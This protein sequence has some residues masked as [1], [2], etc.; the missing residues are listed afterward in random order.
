[1]DKQEVNLPQ[2]ADAPRGT[3]SARID[4][5]GR[6]KLPM[7]VKR[8]L[9]RKSGGRVYC[10]TLDGRM[11]HIFPL[12]EWTKFENELARFTADPQLA[13]DVLIYADN[14]GSDADVDEAGR[15]LLPQ[16]LRRKLN[17][18][19]APEKAE[20]SPVDTVWVRHA[21]GRIEVYPD[22]YYQVRFGQAETGIERKIDV[23]EKANL[24]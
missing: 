6:L 17:L 4:E 10:T 2:D 23:L 16:S 14:F 9:D 3:A 7:D 19:R 20:A 11:A 22:P 1:M 8:Y 21:R 24:L 18:G 5:K 12:D 15:V 13:K